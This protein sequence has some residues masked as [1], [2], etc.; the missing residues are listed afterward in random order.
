MPTEKPRLATPADLAKADVVIS[1]GC[2]LTKF[3]DPAGRLVK[4]DDVPA[5]SEDFA[6][7]DDAI[8]RHVTAL[9]EELVNQV[10][11]ERK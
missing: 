8:R 1:L 9:V 7:G 3:P 10:K 5:L 2:D 6:R 11:S 4:W